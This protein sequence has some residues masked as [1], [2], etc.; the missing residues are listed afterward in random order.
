MSPDSCRRSMTMALFAAEAPMYEWPPLRAAILMLPFA[1]NST[2][3][4]TS[5]VDFTVTTA[6]GVESAN[7][8]LKT[9]FAAPYSA[10]DGRMTRPSI[11]SSRALQSLDPGTAGVVGGPDVAVGFCGS[12]A[13]VGLHDPS[14][15]P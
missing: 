13:A 9:F 5:S 2:A 7:R 15:A 4:R 3:W 12:G 8:E 14:T 10:L 1:A 6:A 11:A